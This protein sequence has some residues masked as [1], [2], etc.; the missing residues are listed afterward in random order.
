MIV[1]DVDGTLTD[2]KIYM[3]V[4]GEVMKAFSTK[5][6]V[7]VRK[8]PKYNILPVIITGRESQITVNRATEIGINEVYQ[9]VLNKIDKLEELIKEKN[10]SSSEIAYI[11]DDE[12]DIECMKKCGFCACPLD[13]V[14]MVKKECDYISSHNGGD[15]A[16]R[17]IIEHII[18]K[19]LD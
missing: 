4:N 15:G 10:I 2:G 14:E 6:A 11:G 8:L 13:A 9:N 17:D 18:I 3:G 19:E 12:N 7:G 16:V 1:F 5:D